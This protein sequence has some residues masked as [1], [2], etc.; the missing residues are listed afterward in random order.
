M[1]CLPLYWYFLGKG[2]KSQTYVYNG[3]HDLLMVSTNF[4]DAAIS[5]IRSVDYCCF[6]S[7][8][9]KIEAANLLQNADLVKKCRALWNIV[10]I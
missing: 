5:N 1:W 2:F 10:C 6:I 8:I 3:C 4:D 7:G 9:S